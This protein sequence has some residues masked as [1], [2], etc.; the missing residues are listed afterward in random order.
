VRLDIVARGQEVDSSG[1]TF[2]RALDDPGFRSRFAE[3]VRASLVEGEIVALPGVLGINDPLALEDLAR[4]IGHELT[5]VVMPPSSVPG[6]RLDQT[7]RDYAHKA[8]VRVVLGASVD[9]VRREAGRVLSVTADT[10]GHATQFAADHFVLA[11]GGFEG[12]AI[13]LDSHGVLTE[14]IFGLPVQQPQEPLVNRD[15][16]AVQPLF[17]AGVAVDATMRPLDASGSAACENLYA[18]GGVIAG[19][20]RWKEKSGEGIAIGSAWKAAQ[21]IR[22]AVR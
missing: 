10:S 12:G 15:Y 2:A 7:L 16:W 3:R 13:E 4:Q 9:T 8:G 5:E 18:I 17:A 21:A 20:Q 19:A 22:E 6:L 14:T 1:L 11:S